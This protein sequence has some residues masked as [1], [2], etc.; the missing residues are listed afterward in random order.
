VSS[1]HALD[2]AAGYVLVIAFALLFAHAALGKWR[3]RWYFEATLA[4]YRL[5]PPGLV[6]PFSLLIPTLEAAVALLL[7]L[8]GPRLLGAF[9]GCALLLVYALAMGINLR[10][11]RH[12]LDC[13]CVGPAARRPI[14][15]WM[16]ARNVLLALL[17]ASSALPWIPRPLDWTDG[18][19][20]AGGVAVTTLL[21]LAADR[22]LG[23]IMPATAALRRAL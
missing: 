22:L 11:D 13:G 14:A 18:L 9:T 20:V 12:D 21:Y 3:N 7:V 10:R 8:K 17:L 16:V 1:L 5:L 15:R 6:R 23:Q 4:N 2:P 19:T